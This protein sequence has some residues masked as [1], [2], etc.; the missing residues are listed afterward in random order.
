MGI[1]EKLCQL[2]KSAISLDCEF[3]KIQRGKPVR[4]V[5]T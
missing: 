1:S 3:S 4:K 2:E 5:A